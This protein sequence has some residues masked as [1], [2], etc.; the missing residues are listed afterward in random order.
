MPSKLRSKTARVSF[1]AFLDMITTVTGV[2]IL[3]TLL[4]TFY[5]NQPTPTEPE[6]DRN[7][8]RAQLEQAKKTL[9]ANLE[10]RA[11]QEAEITAR[12]NRIFLIPEADPSGKQPVL[13]VLSATNGVCGR[14]GQTNLTEFDAD[15]SGS[16]FASLLD[17][18]DASRER[19]VFYVRPSGIAHFDLCRKLA[20]RRAFDVGYDAAEE[21]RSYILARP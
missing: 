14:I 7:Q 21:D 18:L 19:V 20:K 6:V 15:S 12:T 1:L 13:V 9:R 11:R 4:L 2:L 17:G 8:V 10:A 3:V 16:G 5:V